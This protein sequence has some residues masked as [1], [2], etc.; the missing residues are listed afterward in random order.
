MDPSGYLM[1]SLMEKERSLKFWETKVLDTAE[2]ESTLKQKKIK[3]YL[4]FKS[5]FLQIK[6]R[7]L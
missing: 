6:L 3:Y 5:Y 7:G 4:I 2:R 1:L